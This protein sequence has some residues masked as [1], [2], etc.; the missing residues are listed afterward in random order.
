MH[1][2]PTHFA[3]MLVWKHDYDVKIVTSQTAHI[4]YKWPP[5]ATEWPPPWKSS[6]YATARIVI[7]YWLKGAEKFNT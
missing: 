7:V 5:C 4:K 3:K 2:V 6:V 1:I